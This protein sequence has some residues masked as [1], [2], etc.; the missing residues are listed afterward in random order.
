MASGALSWTLDLNTSAFVRSAEKAK[1]SLA[2][3]S[4][5]AFKDLAAPILKTAA[6][7]GSVAAVMEGLKGS[8][9]LGAEMQDLSNRTGIAVDSLAMLRNL[10]K[11]TGLE[12]EN[13]GPVMAKMQKTLAGSV[14]GGGESN[15]LKSLGLDPQALASAAPD[16]AFRKIGEQIAKLP[17]ATEQ[18]AAAMQ[19]FGKSGAELLQVFNSPEFKEAGNVTPAAKLLKENA[20]SFEE[21]S[22]MLGHV[23][24]KLSGFFTGLSS[25]F[26]PALLPLLEKFDK[27][28]FSGWEV[29]LGNVIGNFETDFIDET[30]K[31]GKF[32]QDF[33]TLALTGDT[34]KLFGL[35]LVQKASMLGDALV[36]VFKTPLDYLEAGIQYATEK[37]LAKVGMGT[38]SSFDSI[39]KEV[40]GRG[41]GFQNALGSEGASNRALLDSQISVLSQA[42]GNSFEKIASPTF[43]ATAKTIAANEEARK[44]ADS[45]FKIATGGFDASALGQ[46]G[47]GIRSDSLAKVG[48]GGFSVNGFSNP[49]LDENKRQTSVLQQ[50][51]QALRSGTRLGAAT[52]EG[53]LA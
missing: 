53:A 41:N 29:A 45:K 21:A 2:E 11:D 36:K 16:E 17:N 14:G 50:I 1:K 27:M 28:D 4:S 24:T 7:V 48:G 40:Q 32:L 30:R 31:I 13:I 9:E 26:V 22:Q 43:T 6:A 3:I 51:N 47:F 15:L 20:A 42:L 23:G 52:L 18:A 46:G 10:F 34:L 19:I 8:L 33:I 38:G 37:L 49:I 39:F 5:G 25:S 44:E 35:E 12:A